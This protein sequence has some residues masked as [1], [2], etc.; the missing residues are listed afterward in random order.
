[1][2]TPKML[3]DNN[4]R[5]AEG[6]RA[7]DPEFFKR[8]A[9]GQQPAYLWIGCSDARVPANELV[10]LPPGEVFVQRNLGNQFFPHDFNAV[11]V[12]EFAV[13]VLKV[14]HIIVCGHYGCG[15]VLAALSR[16]APG[17]GL[18]TVKRWITDIRRT[19]MQWQEEL[20]QCADPQARH[21]RLCELNVIQQVEY[22][23]S[24][25]TIRAAWARGQTL[26][27][28]GWIYHLE[29]GLLHD[30]NVTVSGL[31]APS[32]EWAREAQ[33]EAPRRQRRQKSVESGAD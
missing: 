3:L 22:L 20:G 28:H 8:L 6:R 14:Q 29:D 31:D 9:K 26:S 12:A 33:T 5:W 16:T 21:D 17:R 15:A 4:R 27:V 25:P 24:S 19:R 2:I 32:N 18:G 7:Q 11:A 1:M 13:E 30:L 23:R 10:G